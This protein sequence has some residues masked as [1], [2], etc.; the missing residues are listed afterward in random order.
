MG[1]K[2]L[3]TVITKHCP[4]VLRQINHNEFHSVFEN[5]TMAWDAFYWTHVAFK[6]GAIT[7]RQVANKISS[8]LGRYTEVGASGYWVLDG[9]NVLPG[10]IEVAHV[11][12]NA[13]KESAKTKLET[14][15]HQ[16][17]TTAETLAKKGVKP[18]HETITGVTDV[19]IPDTVTCECLNASL[20][21]PSNNPDIKRLQNDFD[22]LH[23]SFI[24]LTTQVTRPQKEHYEAANKAAESCGFQVITAHDEGERLASYM[25]KTGKVDICVT[26]DWD[27]LP[28]GAKHTLRWPGSPRPMLVELDQVLSGLNVTMET[29]VDIC[30]LLGSDYS[31]RIHLVGPKKICDI[32]LPSKCS[33]DQS[34]GMEPTL[35][36][37]VKIE[38][39]ES[40][41]LAPPKSRR[42]ASS[43]DSK[44]ILPDYIRARSYF[45]HNIGP[46]TNEPLEIKPTN[47]VVEKGDDGE[48]DTSSKFIV[49]LQH[50][51]SVPLPMTLD[52]DDVIKSM[53]PEEIKDFIPDSLQ[54]Q[55]LN[56]ELITQYFYDEFDKAVG[57]K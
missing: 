6:G 56:S 4:K 54:D 19:T 11:A 40:L 51:F 52:I 57:L 28:F 2:D 34:I 13:S 10:K 27:A 29:F 12:R 55:P 20:G 3:K 16:L 17:K 25:A 36:S 50:R 1:I 48:D 35:T 49:F 5:K 39:V 47:I 33:N 9:P 8:L 37:N 30:I 38:S 44:K 24:K 41:L 21:L 23:T 7:P 22:D 18:S 31:K 46:G 26:D 14:V 15:K 32:F 43:T 53:T 45:F 42:K